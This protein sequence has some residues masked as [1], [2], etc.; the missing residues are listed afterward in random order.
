MYDCENCLYELCGENSEVCK[1]CGYDVSN[2]TSIDIN[3]YQ[4]N[5]ECWNEVLKK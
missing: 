3:S 4:K 1:N 5:E 2:R